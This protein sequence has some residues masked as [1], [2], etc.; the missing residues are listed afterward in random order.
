MLTVWKIARRRDDRLRLNA[1]EEGRSTG[2]AGMMLALDQ[3]VGAKFGMVLHQEIFRRVADVRHQEGTAPSGNDQL[4]DEGVVVR[5]FALEI[6]RWK[7][8]AGRDAARDSEFIA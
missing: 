1:I 5:A 4:D 7:Q 3:K 2:E 8:N 6:W